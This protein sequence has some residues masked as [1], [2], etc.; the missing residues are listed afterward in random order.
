MV[1]HMYTTNNF[2]RNIDDEEVREQA[3]KELDLEHAIETVVAIIVCILLI[4]AAYFGTKHYSSTH[5]TEVCI[6][7]MI[8]SELDEHVITVVEDKAV[9]VDGT[10]Y[11]WSKVNWVHYNTSKEE[12]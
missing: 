5:Y 3:R 9:Y 11:N 7:G 10:R 6:E 12:D 2:L 4:A 1:Q 8:Y